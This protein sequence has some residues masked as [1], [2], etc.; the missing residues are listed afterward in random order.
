MP[1][2]ISRPTGNLQI[3]YAH[4]ANFP[5]PLFKM[6][7]RSQ[8]QK[9]FLLFHWDLYESLVLL[10]VYTVE[11]CWHRCET[12]RKR[13][14]QFRKTSFWCWLISLASC[15]C[16]F[17]SFRSK[18]C[19]FFKKRG[20]PDSAVSTGKRRALE[21]DRE[22]ALQTSKIEQTN[23]ILFTRTYHPPN[24][25]VKIV[26]LKNLSLMIPKLNI[27]FLYLLLFHS[28][29]TKKKGNFL[30]KSAFK[31]DNQPDTFKRACT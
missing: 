23:R 21:I 29:A 28:N 9:S 3:S 1:G 25:A 26:I 10:N 11:E 6:E 5:R 14:E 8:R 24:L 4:N 22:T 16:T 31:S 2:K 19:Q 18:L 15:A 17:E 20:Y 7:T 12:R 27:Y 13:A 30:F